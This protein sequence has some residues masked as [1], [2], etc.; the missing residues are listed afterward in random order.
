MKYE[1]ENEN[2]LKDKQDFMKNDP[3]HYPKDGMYTIDMNYSVFVW[4]AMYATLYLLMN[5][6]CNSK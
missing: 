3:D 5:C 2:D 4:G 1:G 6:V